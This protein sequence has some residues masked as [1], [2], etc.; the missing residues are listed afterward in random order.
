MGVVIEVKGNGLGLEVVIVTGVIGIDEI[1]PDL[2]AVIVTVVVDCLLCVSSCQ[3]MMESFTSQRPWG[4]YSRYV[5]PP[6]AVPFGGRNTA[7]SCDNCS[8]LNANVQ[9]PVFLYALN[10]R[11][12]QVRSVSSTPS[13]SLTPCL[14]RNTDTSSSVTA[15]PVLSHRERG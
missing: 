12:P 6:V 8:R 4:L 9:F 5:T 2:E 15:I 10:R 13:L 14:C 3:W 11:V 1:H 7:G